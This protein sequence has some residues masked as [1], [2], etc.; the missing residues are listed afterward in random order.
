[1][2]DLENITL[3]QAIVHELLEYEPETGA[4]IWNWRARKW[5]KTDRSW[6]TWNTRYAGTPALASVNPVHGHLCGA[7]FNKSYEAHR[8]IWLYMTARWP[9]PEVDHD[10]QNPADNRWNN[11]REVTRQLNM[12]NQRL[13]RTNKT[14]YVGVTLRKTLTLGVRYRAYITVDGKERH[15]GYFGTKEE[16]TAARMAASEKYGYSDRHGS[17]TLSADERG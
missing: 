9:D 10:N 15:L 4:L 7:I 17:T 3:T 12:K 1:M 16:A 5:F 6:N 13:P 2:A 11:L 8:V 14:G